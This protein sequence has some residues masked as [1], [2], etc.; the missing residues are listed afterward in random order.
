VSAE[1]EGRITPEVELPSEFGFEESR[2]HCHKTTRHHA[3]SFYFSSVALPREK[4]AAAYAVYAFCRHADDLVDESEDP[5]LI[6]A[7]LE[8]LS[9]EF[10]RCRDGVSKEP[11]G[12]ALCHAIKT[13]GLEKKPFLELIEGVASDQGTVELQTWEELER[14]CYHV[15][16]T[17]GLIM[18]PILGLEDEAGK[19]HAIELGIA[20]QLTN[21]SRDIGEDLG[22]GRVYIPAEELKKFGLSKA[23]LESGEIDKSF[24]NLMKFQIS[25][26]RDYY[27]RSEAGIPLLATDGSQFTVWLMRTVYAEI[28]SEIEKNDYDVLAKRASTSLRRK[29]V[30]A[31]RAWKKSKNT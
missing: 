4:R 8:E 22:M 7:A 18:C 28:L 31:A 5:S 19:A 3:K 1:P 15:A 20:M 9:Q 29:L 21:I 12:L 27:D 30:L 17:V 26:A 14:Y 13:Y 24:Q 6:P 23:D 16:S 2:S 10:D 25:R 11:F